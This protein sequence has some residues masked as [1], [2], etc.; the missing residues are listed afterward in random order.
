MS[1][2]NSCLWPLA[3]VL[4]AGIVPEA[5]AR[6]APSSGK[7]TWS[8]ITTPARP[9]TDPK[10]LASPTNSEAKP[11]PLSDLDVNKTAR[12]AVWSADGKSIFVLNNLSGRFNIWRTSA[13][14]SWPVQ[15]TQSNEVQADMAPSPDGRALVFAEDKGGN[16]Y[17]DLMSVPTSGGA[18]ER[19]TNTPDIAEFGAQFSADGNMIA[20]DLRHKGS[21]SSN[22]AVMDFATRTVR[23]LTH[24][25]SREFTW[26]VVRWAP[27]GKSII[28]NRVN[29]LRTRGN[30]WR[31]SVAD[32][33]A[34]ELTPL[35]D[36]A[37]VSASDISADGQTLAITSNKDSGQPH[38]GLLV[39]P[40]KTYRWL[41]P[42]RWEQTS[43]TMS[44]DG[45]TLLIKDDVNG[46]AA[47]S[48]V[49]VATL[50]ERTIALS[51]GVDSEAASI[52]R[53]FSPD[54]SQILIFHA[55]A[56][57]PPELYR[58]N[59]WTSASHPVTQLSMASL[60]P[61]N[62]AKSHIVT[63][64]S[65]DGTLISA[66]VTMPFN[67]KQDGTNPAIVMPHGGPT[68]QSRDNFSNLVA[69][70]ASRGFILIAPNFR[71]S[72]GYGSA[73]QA[74]NIKDLGGADLE[75][76]IAASRFLGATGYVDKSKIGI[77][78]GSYGGFMTLMALGKHPDEFAAGVQSY[79]ILDWNTMWESSDARQR[80]R[81]R[82]LVGDPATDQPLY[83]AQSPI[84]F[85]KK[86]KSPLL[87]LQ[88]EN[89]IRVPRGQAQQV[90]DS[91]KANGT[92]SETIFYP[93]EGHG[94]TKREHVYDALIR[95]IEW[96]DRY[97]KGIAQL[98]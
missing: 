57:T 43:G 18:V 82:V 45:K 93:D 15:I 55:S 37:L 33:A 54:S 85:I 23:E 74:A 92:V 70:L 21:S 88:G 39:L 75:D 83:A 19:L 77:T 29:S 69:A 72:T 14:G 35:T 42:T 63:Y 91:L 16:E 95:T 50:V 81:Q 26:D 71:G 66:V 1:V 46:R 94:F 87:S 5:S 25:S 41:K 48:L 62:L 76:V 53:A 12:S 4:I 11:I 28:A 6:S 31:I 58:V 56:D 98:K 60:A 7:A 65:F 51:P 32:G 52:G 61:A 40:S 44:P 13:D 10:S 97:L 22:V 27:D 2:E 20:L 79:G 24:E 96:F 34:S 47:L 86:V 84:T 9:V 17:Y 49:D 80:E 30:I 89:D 8:P 73:F 36:N 59:P 90:A 38:A 78:G 68:N 67:L 64:R 3:F